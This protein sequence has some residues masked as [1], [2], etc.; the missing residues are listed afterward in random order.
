MRVILYKLKFQLQT[1]FN[2]I[3]QQVIKIDVINFKLIKEKKCPNEL[4]KFRKFKKLFTTFRSNSVVGEVL[5]L[6]FYSFLFVIEFKGSN[7]SQ[8]KIYCQFFSKKRRGI[9][10][11]SSLRYKVLLCSVILVGFRKKIEDN[12]NIAINVKK[13]ANKIN[14]LSEIV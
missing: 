12:L 10:C 6:N 1:M 13:K 14:C 8:M 9:L 7:L 4:N 2:E 3:I 5:N 11:F